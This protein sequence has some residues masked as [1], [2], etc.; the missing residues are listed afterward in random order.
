M[1]NRSSDVASVHELQIPEKARDACNK[2][3]KLLLGKNVAGSIPEFQKAI[4]EFPDY[5]EA[6][7]KLGA[8]EVELQ[9]WDAATAAFRKSVELSDGHYAPAEF[10]LGLIEATVT[11]QFTDAEQVIREGLDVAPND[12]TG[13]YLLGWVLYSTGRLKEAEESARV[14]IASQASF[15]GAHLLLAQIHIKENDPASVLADIDAYLAL[16]IKGPYDDKVHAVRA[17]AVHE[18]DRISADS[19]VASTTAP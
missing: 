3:T 7:G 13:N 6:Y 19:Q 4:K 14:A 16:G 5:F 12:V 1:S 2:G 11:M 10:G 18:L 15:G 8:A 9:Q 17:A